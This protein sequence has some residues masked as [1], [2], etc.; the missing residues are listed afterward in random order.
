MYNIFSLPNGFLHQKYSKE[1]TDLWDKMMHEAAFKSSGGK[2]VVEELTPGQKSEVAKWAPTSYSTKR[3][4]DRAFGENVERV[5]IP[6]TGAEDKIDTASGLKN[7]H[8]FAQQTGLHQHTRDVLR[9][10]DK[11]NYQVDDYHSGMTFHR[12]T[13]NRQIKIGK[14]LQHPDFKDVHATYDEVS[15]DAEGN[16]IKDAS[17][18][19]VKTP[20]KRHISQVYGADPELKSKGRQKAIVITRNRHDVA[21][22]STDRRWKSCMDM[23]D[24]C[25]KHFCPMNCLNVIVDSTMLFW[26]A[27]NTELFALVSGRLRSLLT[28][29]ACV[30]CSPTSSKVF[31]DSGVTFS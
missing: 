30:E 10:L 2:L 12:D 24:G 31:C 27:L 5:V 3:A 29:D 26:V 4:H 16:A 11:K 25:N 1:Q 21:G 22:M 19:T 9:A 13:P 7:E 28:T 17:G 18:N 15:K 23:V 8:D 6:F 20:V 14:V